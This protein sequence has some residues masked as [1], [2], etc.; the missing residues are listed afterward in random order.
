MCDRCGSMT[1][2]RNANPSRRSANWSSVSGAGCKFTYGYRPNRSYGKT[3]DEGEKAADAKGSL[4]AACSVLHES[5]AA[6]GGDSGST[7]PL[8]GNAA[9]RAGTVKV[10]LL[11]TEEPAAVLL[12]CAIEIRS[13]FR[14]PDF[15]EDGGFLEA[16]PATAH[17]RSGARPSAATLVAWRQ[18]RPHEVLH[19]A[20]APVAGRRVVA[21]VSVMLARGPET[22][23]RWLH[24]G[25]MEPRN[26]KAQPG[27]LG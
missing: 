4:Q 25:H 27:R 21:Q 26:N 14:A 23:Y 13:D 3:C 18:A 5:R 1:S 8:P 12:E 24:S 7:R 16:E 2:A 9:H 15:L 17:T 11:R 19:R 10:D 6:E 22:P 20:M